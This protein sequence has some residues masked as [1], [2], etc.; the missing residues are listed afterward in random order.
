MQ[1]NATEVAGPGKLT[2]SATITVKYVCLSSMYCIKCLLCNT[3]AL[4][5][6]G[7]I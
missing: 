4:S 6:M 7:D 1:V 3:M 5:R 2:L